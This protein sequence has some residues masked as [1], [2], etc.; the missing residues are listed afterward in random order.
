MIIRFIG[1]C[2]FAGLALI[3]ASLL[4]P[5]VTVK[6]RPE[7]LTQVRNSVIGTPWG[8]NAAQIL[9]VSDENNVEPLN[10][11]TVVSGAIGSLVSTVE[12]R[13][14]EAVTARLV[15]ELIRQFGELPSDQKQQLQE[16]ICQPNS[17]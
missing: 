9:G 14:Q 6:T 2:I 5:R 4:W 16:I 3:G 13:A 15:R 12:T 7:I 11:G 17:P 10:M 8:G 1:A